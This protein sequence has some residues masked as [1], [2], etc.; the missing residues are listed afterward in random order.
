MCSKERLVGLVPAL[1][2]VPHEA[3]KKPPVPLLTTMTLSVLYAPEQTRGKTQFGHMEDS[4]AVQRPVNYSI[5]LL[6]H[7]NP[8]KRSGKNPAM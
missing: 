5:M 1:N 3:E 2:A 7:G 6:K 4:C 8:E